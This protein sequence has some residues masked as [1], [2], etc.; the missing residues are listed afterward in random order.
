MEQRDDKSKACSRVSGTKCVHPRVNF[1]DL[2]E[3]VAAIAD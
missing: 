3:K 2:H 1:I